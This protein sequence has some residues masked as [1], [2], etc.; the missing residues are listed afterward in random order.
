MIDNFEPQ[1]TS[2]NIIIY[3]LQDDLSLSINILSTLANEND[4]LYSQSIT[5]P[6]RL[7]EYLLSRSLIRKILQSDF[8]YTNPI[9]HLHYPFSNIPYTIALSHAHP[10]IAVS[11]SSN[12]IGLDIENKIP[13]NIEKITHRFLAKDDQQFIENSAHKNAAFLKIWTQKESLLKF[14][15]IGIAGNMKKNIPDIIQENNSAANHAA[16]GTNVKVDWHYWSVADTLL[17]VCFNTQTPSEFILKTISPHDLFLTK[18][19][20]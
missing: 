19:Q 9:D 6:K 8:S 11:I 14:F 12:K 5:N 15:N 1:M 3:L 20:A 18:E 4:L 7:R 2:S 16:Q 10:F 17:S 13:E